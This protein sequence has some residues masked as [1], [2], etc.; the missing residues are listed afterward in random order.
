M[1]NVQ[2]LT[3]R[4]NELTSQIR[5]AKGDEKKRLIAECRE[6]SM[7]LKALNPKVV[8]HKQQKTQKEKDWLEVECDQCGNL[9]KSSE[10][11]RIPV[12]YCKKCR[13]VRQKDL[14]E[15]IN[16]MGNTI[17]QQNQLEEAT[18]ML[19]TL[20]AADVRLDLHKTL[21]TIAPNTKLPTR[22]VCCL[23]YV[24]SLTATRKDARDDIIARIASG[25]IKFGALV[26]RRG[27]HRDPEAANRFTDPGSKAW[28]NQILPAETLEITAKGGKD[29][30]LFVDDS[31]DHV[32]SVQSVGVKSVQIERGG[33]LLKIL[34]DYK[35]T[36]DE[37]IKES[38]DMKNNS[39]RN[40]RYIPPNNVEK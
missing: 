31:E 11:T 23:S 40:Q 21:D 7:K 18:F 10:K 3:D 35:R 20:C 13:K 14:I 2:Q 33:R 34:E 19:K 38:P 27:S 8:E 5:S 1:E 29:V 6:I 9:Y 26:F 39:K 36:T 37:S 17:Y 28:F 22:S 12:I 15:L 25:Q 30:R 32:L 24:G 4:K 16:P